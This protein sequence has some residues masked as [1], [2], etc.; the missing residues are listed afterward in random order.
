MRKN[1]SATCT[2]DQVLATMLPYPPFHFSICDT[3]KDQQV[4]YKSE[5]SLITGAGIKRQQDFCAGR[6]CAHR[7]LDKMGYKERSLH[8]QEQI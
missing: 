1:S 5:L 4:L 2:A 8:G 7:V 6:F 3:P